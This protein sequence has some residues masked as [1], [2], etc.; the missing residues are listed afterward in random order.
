MLG[1]RK[2]TQGTAR[3][4]GKKI[5]GPKVGL[6]WGCSAFVSFIQNQL[7]ETRRWAHFGQL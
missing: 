3:Q 1:D 5:N 7:D 4:I 2:L 6:N